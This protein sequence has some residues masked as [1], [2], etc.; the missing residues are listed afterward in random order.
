LFFIFNANY[1]IK[2]NNRISANPI[3]QH[4]INKSLVPTKLNYRLNLEIPRRDFA[5][6][7]YPIVVLH[8]A[9]RFTYNFTFAVGGLR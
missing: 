1:E 6:L 8:F 5:R 2:D 3:S 4:D 7:A 9:M